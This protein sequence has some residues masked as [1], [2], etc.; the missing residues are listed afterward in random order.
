MYRA[1]TPTHRF[2]FKDLD[3]STFKELN[4]YYA[5]QGVEILKKEKSDF[6][7]TT[8]DTEDGVLYIAYVVLTQE[9]T[10]LFKS[11]KTPVK[12][13]LRALTLDNKALATV[14]YEIP[15]FNVIND[16]VLGE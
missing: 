15:V 4:V 5:Q 16:E 13:Q 7:F 11:G 14:E 1:T 10:K 2:E 8:Q 6:Q 12:I 3:P 9:E